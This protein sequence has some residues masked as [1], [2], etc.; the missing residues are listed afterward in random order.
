M[1]A[2]Q[3]LVFP[4]F[5]CFVL[6]DENNEEQEKLIENLLSNQADYI[7]YFGKNDHSLWWEK[8][9]EIGY[10]EFIPSGSFKIDSIF[11]KSEP[12]KNSKE[13]EMLYDILMDSAEGNSFSYFENLPVSYL[14]A[15]LYQYS[16]RSFAFTDWDLS[17]KSKSGYLFVKLNTEKNEIIQL[18]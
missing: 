15:P 5:R 9:Q 4:A 18:F 7:P 12:L 13:E 2:E 14:G 3:T 16:Y 6:L 17:F 1:V 11:I 10:S 8:Q